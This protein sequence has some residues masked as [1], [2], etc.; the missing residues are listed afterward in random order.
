MLDHIHDTNAVE[1]HRLSKL[2]PLPD[3]VKTASQE[4][5]FK[6]GQLSI[7]VYADPHRRLFP[8]HTPAAT[9]LSSLYFTEKQAEYNSKEAKFV[10]ARLDHYAKYWGIKDAV[11]A[12]GVRHADLTKN[13]DDKLPDGDFAIV[14]VLDNGTKERHCRMKNA[15]EVK[16]AAD[17]LHKHVDALPFKDRQTV[18]NKIL[19]KAARYGASLGD[20][21]TFVER[22]AGRG[23]CNPAELT[24]VLLNRAKLARDNEQRGAMTKLAT[25]VRT[26]PRSALTPDML[27]KLAETLDQFD[28]ANGLAGKYTNAIPRPEDAIFSL[29]L[30][31]ATAAVGS[32]VALTTNR[33]Y[34]RKDFK[35]IKL[36]DLNDL[37]GQSFVDAVADGLNVD[38]EKLAEQ[39]SA[40]PRPDAEAFEQIL[41]DAKIPPIMNKRG[42]DLSMPLGA[43]TSLASQY[44]RC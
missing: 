11:N 40:L 37:F 19:E 32:A 26:E 25:M 7:T 6:P 15:R 38:V 16:A 35:Q 21:D 44:A 2:Y 30:K 41:R 36:A 3:F 29:T 8:C 20:V 31:E 27:G 33:V 23:I 39:V 10:Q 43:L 5:T 14:Y 18:A 22:L 42:S 4:E 17:W 24:T 34:D 28:R 9:W 12:I 1:L 13:A